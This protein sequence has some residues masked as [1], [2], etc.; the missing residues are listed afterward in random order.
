M[1]TPKNVEIRYL[2]GSENIANYSSQEDIRKVL[3]THGINKNGIDFFKKYQ[4]VTKIIIQDNVIK[5]VS[6]ESEG[7]ERVT[8]ADIPLPIQLWEDREPFFLEKSNHGLH[9]VGGIKPQD[10]ILPIDDTHASP[11]IYFATIDGRDDCFRWMNV[12]ALHLA[13]P[14]YEGVFGVFLDYENPL[15]P[16]II[17]IGYNVQWPDSTMKGVEKIEYSKQTYE[18][19]KINTEHDQ[20]NDDNLLCGVPLWYQSPEI[21]I[22]PKS[23]NVMRFVATINSDKTIVLANSQGIEN[24]PL[25][26]EYLIFGDHGNMFVFYEPTS[27]VAHMSFQF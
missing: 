27:K 11:F 21:P 1:F 25:G 5:K 9:S 15:C 7:D 24:I 26:G 10:F 3:L 6:I 14:I 23:G 16:K 2:A 18:Y 22:C 17:S 12:E 20:L 8:E 4:S 19:K 13:Y